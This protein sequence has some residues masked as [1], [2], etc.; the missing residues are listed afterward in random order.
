[1]GAI[2]GFKTSVRDGTALIE[3]MDGWDLT[4]NQGIS[5]YSSFG[6]S[7][8]NSFANIKSW[9]AAAKGTLD[10]TATVQTALFDQL[11]SG[12]TE[13][14]VDVRFYMTSTANVPYWGGNAKIEN[15]TV[16]SAVED[17][18]NVSI[19]FRGNGAI[20]RTTAT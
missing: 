9:T 17:K 7:Y 18:V 3:L 19:N 4:F 13:A 11:E 8:K 15:M 16:N 14:D 6:T 20:S 2:N 5:D 1:M 12:G 10:S